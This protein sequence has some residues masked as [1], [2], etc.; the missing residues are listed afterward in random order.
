[1]GLI[2]KQV[3]GVTS[4]IV[5]ALLGVWNAEYRREGLR[6]RRGISRLAAAVVIGFCGG[7]KV[8]EFFLAL[9]K[10]MLYLWE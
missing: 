9:L 2:K 7:L 6:R 8:E 3:L 1:M 10:G 5:K 4:E